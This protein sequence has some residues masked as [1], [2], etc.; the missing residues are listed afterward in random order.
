MRI[1]RFTFKNE[2]IWMLISSIGL[3][4]LGLVITL[5]VVL[6]RK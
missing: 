4:L 3:F 5:V 6:A 2:A 1:L